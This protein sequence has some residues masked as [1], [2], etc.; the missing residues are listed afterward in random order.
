VSIYH[1]I[2]APSHERSGILP[3]LDFVGLSFGLGL[4]V[5]FRMSPCDLWQGCKATIM[6]SPC[7]F[8]QGCEATIW[9]RVICVATLDP[10]P[11]NEL[12]SGLGI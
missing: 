8:W 5:R 1:D 4:L 6:M 3:R 9:G 10:V 2:H 12:I 7:D 11:F